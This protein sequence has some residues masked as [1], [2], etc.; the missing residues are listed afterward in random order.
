MKELLYLALA[1]AGAPEWA[2]GTPVEPRAEQAV[3]MAGADGGALSDDVLYVGHSLVSPTLPQMISDLVAD[4]GGSAQF[5]VINGAPLIWNWEHSNE[6]QGVDARAV[7]PKG[8][9]EVLVIAEG[10]PILDHATWSDSSA[11]ALL[12]RDLAVSSNA[13]AR[14]YLYEIWPSFEVE[15]VVAAWHDRIANERAIFEGI[16]DHV[17]AERSA[18]PEMHIIPGGQAL[19]RMQEE[20]EAGR[21]PGLVDI[22]DLFADD[23]HLNYIGFYYM[24]MVHYAVIY[25]RSPEGL[26][27]QLS[28]GRGGSFEAPSRELATRMQELAWEVVRSYPKSGIVDGGHG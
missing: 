7:L 16:V 11:Y 17:N 28:D 1:I 4:S 27:H 14:V 21:V 19:A 26:P 8:D 12:W 13:N 6:A 20:I 25:S 23:I 9:T 3:P 5:Q 15:P 24:A 10:G 22:R 2:S 18:G